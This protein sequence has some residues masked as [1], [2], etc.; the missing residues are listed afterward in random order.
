MVEVQSWKHDFQPC[1]AVV[2]DCLTV[3]LLWLHHIQSLANVTMA[4]IATGQVG[5]LV[6]PRTSY[7]V[8]LGLQDPWNSISFNEV[9]TMQASKIRFSLLPQSITS[10]NS[11]RGII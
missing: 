8:K 5:K 1:T 7:V 10:T 6:L 2:W 3:G 9:L 4:T 11:G